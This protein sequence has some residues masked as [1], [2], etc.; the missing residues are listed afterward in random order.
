MTDNALAHKERT[1]Q[2]IVDELT[3]EQRELMDLVVGAAVAD[4]IIEDPEVVADYDALPDEVKL[5]IDFIVGGVLA[6]QDGGELS[7]DALRVTAFLSH[8]GVKGMKWGVRNV[9]SGGSSGGGAAKAARKPPAPLVGNGTA[10]KLSGSTMNTKENRAAARKQVL[11]GT[12]SPE[13]AHVAALK[14]NGHRVAN[15]FLGDKS[16]WKGVAL[17]AGLAGATVGAGAL[18]PMVLPA[19]ALAAI[20]N[21]AAFA[22]SGGMYGVSG[23]TAVGY[24]T[25]AITGLTTGAAYLGSSIAGSVLQVTNLVR[26]VRGNSRID[27]SYERLGNTAVANQKKGM[28]QTAKILRKDGG[29]SRT[30]KALK[31]SDELRVGAFIEHYADTPV[32]RVPKED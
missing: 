26:A 24:G 15:A 4:E 11:K 14:S 3:P 30:K 5:L 6:Q 17:T 10:A 32:V 29:L 19:S 28:K 21:A 25:A 8:F 2:D 20:G 1:L 9:D 22:A 13:T 23:A 12:A 27:A 16:Y 7:Q 18:A 31:Q